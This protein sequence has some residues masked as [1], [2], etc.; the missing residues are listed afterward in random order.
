MVFARNDLAGPRQSPLLSLMLLW[1]LGSVA[2]GLLGPYGTWVLLP[3]VW[4]LAFWAG[5]LI[6]ALTVAEGA[7]FL[8]RVILPQRPYLGLLVE[9]GLTALILGP[10]IW[11]LCCVLPHADPALV[12]PPGKIMLAVFALWLCVVLLRGL[13]RSAPMPVATP[14]NRSDVV[15]IPRNGP[16]IALQRAAAATIR[17]A[18]LERSDLHLPGAVMRVSADDHYLVIQTTHGTG[19]IIMRFRDALPDLADLPGCRIH[20]SHWVA[21]D[22]MLRVRAEGRRHVMD[23]ID[24]S[25]LPVSQAYL[26]PLRALGLCDQR[27]IG[28]QMGGDPNKIASASRDINAASSGRSQ[29]N[30]P[31]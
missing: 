20:R 17:P 2:L 29:N 22:A 9:G 18:F 5:I 6:A 3:F 24:G 13:P 10:M 21:T 11:S 26:G 23:L 16:T 14:V 7:A 27:G 4:R 1:L 31:V 25:S 12:P 19:R 30:P 28:R 8:A 15:T